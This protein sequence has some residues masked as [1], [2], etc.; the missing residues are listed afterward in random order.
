MRYITR[1]E[2][3][4]EADGSRQDPEVENCRGEVL[5][6]KQISRFAEKAGTLIR[7]V[8]ITL[9]LV[10]TPAAHGAIFGWTDSEGTKHFTNK[11][12]DIPPRYRD[13]AKLMYPEPTDSQIP[14]Q[15]GQPKASLQS[16]PRSEVSP[17]GVA[18]PVANLGQQNAS[19]IPGG[20]K[21]IPRHRQLRKSR[22][23]TEE[24]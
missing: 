9:L 23:L 12:S 15:A 22:G 1:Y 11:E 20:N 13:K 8:V 18:P 16:T 10:L 14:Q 7:A 24:E 5:G 3:D 4:G 19:G 2:K 17:A 21:H 6:P